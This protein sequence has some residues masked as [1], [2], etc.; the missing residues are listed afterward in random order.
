MTCSKDNVLYFKDRRSKKDEITNAVH[1]SMVKT[2]VRNIPCTEQ[3]MRM[4]YALFGDDGVFS[5]DGFHR[6]GMV[7]VQGS[8]YVTVT[9]TF[10]NRTVV[11]EKLQES[12][13]ANIGS[14][15]FSVLTQMLF[16]PEDITRI[17]DW[18]IARIKL[19]DQENEPCAPKVVINYRCCEETAEPT[20]APKFG[21]ID[22]GIN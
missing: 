11:L 2:D 21:S 14:G 5:R 19:G 16:L 22:M 4:M 8:A 17:E 6:F 12:K 9:K 7:S 18:L 1:G 13:T 20:L 15:V 3:T 10:E